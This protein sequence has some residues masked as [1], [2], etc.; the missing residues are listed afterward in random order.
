[1][2]P[3]YLNIAFVH[4]LAPETSNWV[5]AHEA[6]REHLEKVMGD[7]V[8]VQRFAGVGNGEDAEKAI[9]TANKKRSGYYFCNHRTFDLG[10]QKNCRQTPGNQNIQLLCCNAVHR[11]AHLLLP[12]LRG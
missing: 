8:V 4:E 11:C 7:Q 3:S 2:L 5:R 12:N 1:M 9:E 10:L 6:G